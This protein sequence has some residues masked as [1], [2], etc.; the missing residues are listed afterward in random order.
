MDGSDDHHPQRTK[1]HSE[2]QI[3]HVF[4]H[5]QNLDFKKKTKIEGGLFGEDK[6]ER[7]G[8]Q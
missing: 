6:W 2:R 7:G 3:S 8:R 1:S 4:Y 5:M